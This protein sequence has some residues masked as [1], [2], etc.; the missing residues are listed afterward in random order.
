MRPNCIRLGKGN[1][2]THMRA[3]FGAVKR[4]DVGSRWSAWNELARATEMIATW[5]GI[6]L[7]IMS[8]AL[9]MDSFSSSFNYWLYTA[10]AVVYLAFS[11]GVSTLVLNLGEEDNRGRRVLG[12]GY[13]KLR[14]VYGFVMVV[15]CPY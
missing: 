9:L 14:Q 3:T 10:A 8:R 11:A 13:L 2:G 4:C 12:Q 5:N 1:L 15:S 6:S 7:L